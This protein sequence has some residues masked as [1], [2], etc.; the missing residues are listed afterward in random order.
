MALNMVIKSTDQLTL[1][2]ES[3]QSLSTPSFSFLALDSVHCHLD[4]P[5]YR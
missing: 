5:P 2:K 4:S 1:F 3:S